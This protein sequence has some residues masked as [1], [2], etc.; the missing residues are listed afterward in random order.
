MMHKLFPT[1][2]AEYD[3]SDKVDNDLIMEK[4]K[5]S[6]LQMHGTLNKGVSS[7][8]GGYDCALT[9]LAMT[10]LQSAIKEC[11]DDYCKEVGLEENVIVNS[12]CN[13]LK[14]GGSVKRHRHDKS[15]L[16]GAYYPSSDPDDCPLLIENPTEI[17]KMTETKVYDTEFNVSAIGV[18]TAKG[19]LVIWPSYLYHETQKNSSDERY[20][21]SF[22][23]LDKS[24][25]NAIRN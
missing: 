15:V 10:D 14:E 6:G 20:T 4:V 17:F 22:N 16:S 18:P 23:T 1:L 21:I 24:Y 11:L 9:R 7:Y 12:W 2:V 25:L 5:I 8:M 13:I 3:L 19:K